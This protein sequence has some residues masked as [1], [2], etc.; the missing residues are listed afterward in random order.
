MV[1]AGSEPALTANQQESMGVLDQLE[2]FEINR[3]GFLSL[4]WKTNLKP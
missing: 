1:R 4:A 3:P 2:L